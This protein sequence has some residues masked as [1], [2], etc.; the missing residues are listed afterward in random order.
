MSSH[1]NREWNCVTLN[2]HE[3]D[4]SK[5]SYGN[6]SLPHL[7]GDHSTRPEP[8]RMVEWQP[9]YLRRRA[10][11][12]FF[13][14]F[15]GCIVVLQALLAASDRNMGL[16]ASQEKLH[17]LWTYGPTAMLTLLAAFWAR[18]ASQAKLTAPW[19]N[20]YKGPTE[21]E[22]SIL[23]DYLSIWQPM[24]VFAALRNVDYTVAATSANVMIIKIL[25]VV[26]TAL[27]TL[28]PVSVAH[29]EIP[30]RVKSEFVD[31]TSGFS[32]APLAYYAFR[33]M[34]DLQTSEND[35]L[36]S[37][38]AYQLV[39][40]VLPTTT[41]FITTV[42]GFSAD[43]DCEAADVGLIDSRRAVINKTDYVRLDLGLNSANCQMK[44]KLL[45]PSAAGQLGVPHNFYRFEPGTCVGT[46]ASKDDLRVGVVFSSINYTE[47]ELVQ[48]VTKPSIQDVY[49][50]TSHLL[51]SRGFVCKPTYNIKTIQ[52]EKNSTQTSISLPAVSTSRQLSQVHPWDIMT[53]HFSSFQNLLNVDSRASYTTNYILN[54][55]GIPADVDG[56][57]GL[58][59]ELASTTTGL[60]SAAS[61]L[62]EGNGRRLIEAYYQQYAAI[63]AHTMLTQTSSIASVGYALMTEDRLIVRSLAAH[64][65]TGSLVLAMVLVLVVWL[66]QP[67]RTVLPRSPSTPIGTA[68]LLQHSKTVIQSLSGMGAASK[69]SLGELLSCWEYQSQR[70]DQG[71]FTINHVVQSPTNDELE[72]RSSERYRAHPRTLQPLLRFSVYLLVAGI[73]AALEATLRRSRANNGLGDVGDESFVHYLWT[74]IPAI[75]LTLLGMYFAGVDFDVKSLT[76]YVNLKR[77]APF[78]TS[79]GLDLV[80]RFTVPTILKE[81]ETRSFAALACTV[82]VALTSILTVFT[83]SLFYPTSVLSFLPAQLDTRSLIYNGVVDPAND[84]EGQGLLAA[85]LIFNSNL[86]YPAFTYEDLVFPDLD[87]A[88][89]SASGAL[90]SYNTSSFVTN[91][92]ITAVRPRLSCRIYEPQHIH[93]N[94]S[95]GQDVTRIFR[96]ASGN[97][98]VAYRFSNPL[99][100]VVDEEHCNVPADTGAN[101]MLGTGTNTSIDGYFAYG[102]T[103]LPGA[104]VTGCSDF[105]YMWGG[106]ALTPDGRSVDELSTF[107]MGCNESLESVDVAATFFGADLRIDPGY[108]PVVDEES[109]KAID[110]PANIKHNNIYYRL[111][112]L[113]GSYGASTLDVFFLTATSSR[114]AVPVESL[115]D[116][117]Q[118]SAVAD[119]V[120]FHHC[121]IRAQIASSSYRG[122][123]YPV[124]GQISA[125]LRVVGSVNDTLSHPAAI[126]DTSTRRRVVQDPVSTHVIEALLAA[127]LVCS[128]GG[129]LLMRE[130][131]VLPRSPTSISSAAALLADGNIFDYLPDDVPWATKENLAGIFGPGAIFRLGWRPTLDGTEERFA[132]YVEQQDAAGVEGQHFGDAKSDTEA[133]TS[134]LDGLSCGKGHATPVLSYG[135]G[136]DYPVTRGDLHVPEPTRKPDI[137]R[138]ISENSRPRGYDDM[139]D[140]PVSPVSSMFPIQNWDDSPDLTE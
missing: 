122:P 109:A 3:H 49:N 2:D 44:M 110:I 29:S 4:Y 15:A 107:A 136:E 106:W 34:V 116:A 87:L 115:G 83:S 12:V 80:N 56:P 92:T 52:L 35:G 70:E 63:I 79:M 140:I 45:G 132:I 104:M 42:D 76:P 94:I 103:T 134:S 119:S 36:Q 23:L 101:L 120:R 90:S 74:T 20:M 139:E 19:I 18:V 25:I 95:I 30:L 32:N 112:P 55:T 67:E 133:P 24:S 11:A 9:F 138:S 137:H 123:V 111:A 13:I 125:D 72:M 57:M 102:D 86:S 10:L 131:N 21:A 126:T 62:D 26:S 38:Y 71:R 105:L 81:I 31:S 37:N 8:T 53:A 84:S 129:W 69:R 91:A 48:H 73:I 75:V 54:S 43:L 5:K 128:I 93:A 113:S 65:M 61:L 127:T 68:I 88:L 22:R 41:H 16:G 6:A 33:G 28:S 89:G 17:Y 121:I 99:S 66:A 77:G 117:S 47:M 39:K 96:N 130:T 50:I 98:T 1:A 58:A 27:I 118:M 135:R 100:I 51:P 108:P 40:A 82:T 46:T 60:P 59:F 85:S 124:A 78:R 7:S 64:L 114:Y 97:T 14:V